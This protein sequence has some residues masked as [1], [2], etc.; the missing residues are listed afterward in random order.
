MKA[1]T[2]GLSKMSTTTVAVKMLKGKGEFQEDVSL[3]I[4]K[5]IIVDTM[6]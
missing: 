3:R 6:D 2:Y 4:L 5:G 1:E